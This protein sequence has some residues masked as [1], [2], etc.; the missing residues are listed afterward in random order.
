MEYPQELRD[1]L[2]R[3]LREKQGVEIPPEIA[4]EYLGAL[5]DLYECYVVLAQRDYESR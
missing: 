4:D 2:V 1:R 5:A 3:Y